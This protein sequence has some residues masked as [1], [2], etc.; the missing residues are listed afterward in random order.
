MASGS[1]YKSFAELSESEHEGVSYQR[2]VKR[3][4]SKLAIIAPHGGGIEP[5]TSEIA[6]SMAGLVF[7]YYV[8][9]GRRKEGNEL[10]HIASTLFDEPKCLKLVHDSQVVIA[11]H[12]CAGEEKVVYV[13]GLHDRLKTRL[14]ET[15]LKAGFDARLA[16]GNYAGLQSNN[17]CNCGRTGRGV[18]FEITEG[19]RRTMFRALNRPGRKMT[20]DVFRKFVAAIHKELI[21]IT[22]EKAFEVE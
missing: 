17:L 20:T 3:R 18:Q 4:R 8:F 15:M 19:L 16:E 12:G 9:D 11:I 22:K 1:W 5:G 21:A 7:S 14:I 2:R 13:G 10:L 6:A